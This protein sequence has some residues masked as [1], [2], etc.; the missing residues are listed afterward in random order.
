MTTRINTVKKYLTQFLIVRKHSSYK[1]TNVT[2]LLSD[3]RKAAYSYTHPNR[4]VPRSAS[5]GNLLERHILEPY[6][7]WTES[8]T[9]WLGPSV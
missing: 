1:K 9:P 8:E 7:R 2:C 4:V 3:G 6:P 5:S